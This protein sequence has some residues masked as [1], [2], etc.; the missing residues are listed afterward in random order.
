MTVNLDLKILEFDQLEEDQIDA[1]E[2][3]EITILRGYGKKPKKKSGEIPVTMETTNDDKITISGHDICTNL[4]WYSFFASKYSKYSKFLIF[5][6]SEEHPIGSGFISSNVHFAAYLIKG[7]NE[8]LIASIN[9]DV[10]YRLVAGK[11]LLPQ[12]LAEIM[13]NSLIGVPT[14]NDLVAETVTQ[15]AN[16][17]VFRN[18]RDFEIEVDRIEGEISPKPD[19]SPLTQITVWRRYEILLYTLNN[20]F[21][22]IDEHLNNL[23]RTRP[24]DYELVK[25][26]CT[27]IM[28]AHKE[29]E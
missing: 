2:P 23:G 12:D 7:I 25:K 10:F 17:F 5:A 9:K 28:E 26:I 3:T 18:Q 16:D 27:E 4:L 8:F 21:F 29:D 24:L 6:K 13:E 1:I 11:S 15:A 20:I 14:V 22:G 19:E